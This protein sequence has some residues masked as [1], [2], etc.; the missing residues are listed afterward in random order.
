MATT[1]SAESHKTK[2]LAQRA[3]RRGRTKAAKAGGGAKPRTRNERKDKPAP[4]TKGKATKKQICIDLLSRPD[5]A[6]IEELQEA[7]GWQA[8]S[9]RGFLA[10]AVKKGLGLTLDSE[11]PDDGPRRYRIISAEG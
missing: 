1:N 7:T 4:G 10:G 2:T 6:S 3:A 9:V 11:K 8:H 5:G